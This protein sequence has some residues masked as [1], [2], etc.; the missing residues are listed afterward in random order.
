MLRQAVK[1][2]SKVTVEE[3]SGRRTM[4]DEEKAEWRPRLCGRL[5]HG[6]VQGSKSVCLFDWLSPSVCLGTNRHDIRWQ[7]CN[8][9]R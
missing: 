3:D 2:E 8:G 5:R 6:S 1:V 4:A 7:D 9:V